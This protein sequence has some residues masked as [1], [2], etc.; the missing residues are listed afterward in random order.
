MPADPIA[1]AI[2]AALAAGHVML[3]YIRRELDVSDRKALERAKRLT[4]V[5]ELG[6]DATKARILVADIVMALHIL[7]GHAAEVAGVTARI[8]DAKEMHAAL[9]AYL[10]VARRHSGLEEI[11][12]E[13]IFEARQ[14]ARFVDETRRLDKQPWADEASDDKSSRIAQTRRLD[15]LPLRA[16]SARRRALAWLSH[17]VKALAGGWRDPIVK[18]LAKALFNEAV[19]VDDVRRSTG[20]KKTPK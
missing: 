6:L 2:D 15:Y 18:D 1:A 8:A 3:W 19:S 12:R 14:L 11:A 13:A 16:D 5:R 4:S 9:D 7:K 10:A 20:R 17:S